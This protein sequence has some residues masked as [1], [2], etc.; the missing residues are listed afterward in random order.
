MSKLTLSVDPSVVA[1]AK[2]YAKQNGI[3]LSRMVETYLASISAP[4]AAKKM[5]PVLRSLRG[6]LNRA[7]PEDYKKHLAEK[8]L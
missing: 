4:P 6:I 7:D 2:H 1:R 5:P 8:Y 3:S